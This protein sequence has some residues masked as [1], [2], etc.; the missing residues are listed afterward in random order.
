MEHIYFDGPGGSVLVECT[1]RSALAG[2]RRGHGIGKVSPS[3]TGPQD[4]AMEW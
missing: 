3:R 4:P 1:A 2:V